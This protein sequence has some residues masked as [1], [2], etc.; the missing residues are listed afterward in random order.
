M[1]EHLELPSIGWQ[2]FALVGSQSDSTASFSSLDTY[3]TRLL[4]EPLRNVL[5]RVA[6]LPTAAKVFLAIAALVVLGIVVALS[7]ILAV[8]ALL[9]LIVAVVALV[10]QLLRRASLRRWGIVAAVSLVL[11]LLFSG[12]SNALYFGGGQE[13]ATSPEQTS[14]PEEKS[15][16][17]KPTAPTQDTTQAATEPRGN[18]DDDQGR[19]DA[20]ATVTDVVDGDTVEIDPAVDG[21]REVRLIGVDTPETKDPDEEVEPYGPEASNYATTELDGEK[22]ELELDS[23]TTDQYGRLLA[24]VYPSGEEMFNEDLLTGGYAQVYTVP[25]ND[26]YQDRFESAQE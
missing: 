24:Y 9:V 11:L 8:L 1:E 19:Y 2:L 13:Q 22:V 23:E 14:A 6:A 4:T 12:I 5:N 15:T 25:P 3:A 17:A 7:P 10:I 21:K 16:T 18:E 20:V 26:E